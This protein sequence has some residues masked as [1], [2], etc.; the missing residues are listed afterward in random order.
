[1]A[2]DARRVGCE[3]LGNWCDKL[4]SVERP[5]KADQDCLD[6]AMCLLVAIRW[7]VEGLSGCLVLGDLINGYMVLPATLLVRQKL[8][9]AAGAGR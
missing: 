6:A 9:L 5:R 1:V 3:A 7:R 2:S 8:A 4:V